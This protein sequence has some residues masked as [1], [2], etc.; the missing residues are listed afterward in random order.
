MESTK[1]LFTL[2][3]ETFTVRGVPA[4]WD[5]EESRQ[6]PARLWLDEQEISLQFEIF[7]SVWEHQWSW[8]RPRVTREHAHRDTVEVIGNYFIADPELAELLWPLINEQYVEL[9]PAEEP[10]NQTINILDFWLINQAAIA[11]AQQELLNDGRQNRSNARFFNEFGNASPSPEPSSDEEENAVA[12][13]TDVTVYNR[14]QP[15]APGLVYGPEAITHWLEFSTGIPTLPGRC[16]VDV[17]PAYA[18]VI[19]TDVGRGAVQHNIE[20]LVEQVCRRLGVNSQWMRLFQRYEH[21]PYLIDEVNY[22]A[23]LLGDRIYDPEWKT[24]PVEQF[25]AIIQEAAQHSTA[26]D[27][28]LKTLFLRVYRLYQRKTGRNGNLNKHLP[29][30]G[31]LFG[32]RS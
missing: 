16:R 26:G 2:L 25:E 13:N 14:S 32:R 10:F 19:L 4:E 15:G 11:S 22:C 30:R 23:S 9:W 20:G 18:L 27:G 28:W 21:D 24:V 29:L 1:S 3:A 5:W 7:G 31:L 17:F 8:G 6:R 12:W